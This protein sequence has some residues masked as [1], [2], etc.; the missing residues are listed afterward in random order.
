[1]L[2]NSVYEALINL[3]GKKNNN[4]FDFIESG[5]VIKHKSGVKYTVKKI[6]FNKEPV[7]L[8]YRYYAKKNKKVYILIT[9]KDFKNY[10]PA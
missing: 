7:V 5:L 1:M 9:K 2:S 8:A 6:I 3:G 4:I 10:E